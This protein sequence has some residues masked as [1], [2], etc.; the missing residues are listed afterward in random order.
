[1]L[2]DDVQTIAS[3]PTVPLGNADAESVL[4]RY[5]IHGPIPEPATSIESAMPPTTIVANLS[6]AVDAASECAE[7][8]GYAPVVVTRSLDCE[9]RE[10]GRLFASILA[11]SV[12]ARTAF[13]GRTCLLAGGEMT[14]T[15]HGDG[16]GGRNTEAALAAAIR[17]AGVQ[18]AAIGFLASDGDDGASGASGGIVDGATV[19]DAERND[20]LDAL[21]KNDSYTFLSRRGAALPGGETGTNVNDLVIGLIG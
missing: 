20:A 1:V 12:G 5:G 8:L 9:A 7:A 2:G 21:A 19:S 3:G 16:T 10:A 11:D 4:L 14:V 17:L 15:V 6:T 13:G 18:N